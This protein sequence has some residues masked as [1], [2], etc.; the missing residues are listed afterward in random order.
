MTGDGIVKLK[1]DSIRLKTELSTLKGKNL[2][3]Y[4]LIFDLAEHIRNT[5]KKDLILTMIDR[6]PAEQDEL[7]KND[8]RYQAKKFKSPHQFWHAVDIRSKIFTKEEIASI[9]K[10]LNDKCNATNAYAW[11]A[12]CHA[13]GAGAEHFHIQYAKK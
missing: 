6:T 4:D 3:L 1:N 12:K 13:V 2:P 10:H 11:T 7:Y 8:K 5:V 9:V